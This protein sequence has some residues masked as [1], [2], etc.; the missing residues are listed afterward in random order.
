[1]AW[2]VRFAEHVGIA[3]GIAALMDSTKYCA[4][5]AVDVTAGA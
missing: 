4:A 5:H 1:M 3:A 2:L